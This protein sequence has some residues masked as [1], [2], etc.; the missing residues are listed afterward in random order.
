MA[1]FKV[2]EEV[3]VTKSRSKDS[4][5]TFH[6]MEVIEN[7]CMGGTQVAYRGTAWYD[8]LSSICRHGKTAMIFFEEELEP[9]LE[10]KGD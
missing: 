6:I 5:M 4:V 10:R 3:V 8:S 2:G 1:K 7:S 9:M